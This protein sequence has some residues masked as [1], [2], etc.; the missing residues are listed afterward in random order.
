MTL[1][2]KP[3]TEQALAGWM[4]RFLG[5]NQVSDFVQKEEEQER[6]WSDF[7]AKAVHDF[8]APLTAASGYC[9][10][11]LGDE[12][13]AL[14][15]QQKEILSRTQ[16]S[17]LRLARMTSDVLSRAADIRKSVQQGK[18]A[19]PHSSTGRIPG[20]ASG[21]VSARKPALEA[22]EID[23]L[24]E[25]AINEAQ[26]AAMKKNIRIAGHL[27]PPGRTMCFDWSQLQQVL[28]NL[29]EN[30]CKFTPSGGR[31]EVS[32]YPYGAKFFRVDVFNTGAAISPGRLAKIFDEGVSFRIW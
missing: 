27:T 9:G 3:V 28:A 13:G 15:D 21:D 12:L 10:L 20:T 6:Q 23:A 24:I 16:N 18:Q 29:L 2:V 5:N 32:G 31:I 19:E 22:G 11:L 8:R 14:T 1:I 30:A 4:N 17:L 25:Q 26:L 7:L